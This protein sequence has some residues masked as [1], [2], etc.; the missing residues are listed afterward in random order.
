ME[1]KMPTKSTLRSRSS[2][3]SNAFA[4]SV[5]PFIKPSD[6]EISN[7]LKLL[8]VNENQCAY[9]LREGLSKDHLKPLVKKGMPTGYI[10]SIQNLVPCCSNCNSSKGAKSFTDWYMSSN[11]VKRL[12]AI[13]LSDDMI[14]HRYN[15]IVKYENAIGEPLNYEDIVGS[16]LWAEYKERRKQL[17]NILRDNQNF[18]DKL[19]DIILKKLKDDTPKKEGK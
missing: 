4:I 14:K 11:N 1:Y 15:I 13:G 10:T 6:V 17:L 2:T 16:E 8:E 5:T 9:C 7:S 12:K 19:N 3:I 18:C